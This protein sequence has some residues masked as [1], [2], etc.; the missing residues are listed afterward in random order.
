MLLSAYP[1]AFFQIVCDSMLDFKIIIEF[2]I[3]TDDIFEITSRSNVVECISQ[4]LL[5]NSLCFYVSLQNYYHKYHRHRRI[6]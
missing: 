5:L 1:N 4:R 6:V 2:I 3:G